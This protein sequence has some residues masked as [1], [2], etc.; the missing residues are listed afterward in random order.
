M[1]NIYFRFEDDLKQTTPPFSIGLRLQEF[2]INTCN[3][4][5]AAIN[6]ETKSYKNKKKPNRVHFLTYKKISIKG[7][8]IFCDYDDV[9][10]R[11]NG[12]IDHKKLAEELEQ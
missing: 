12:G 1:K 5:F 7:F 3:E 6:M 9:N 4:D 10:L 11:K 2:S 8:S